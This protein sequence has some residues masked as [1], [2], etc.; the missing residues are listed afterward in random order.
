MEGKMKIIIVAGLFVWL[1][2]VLYANYGSGIA[3]KGNHRKDR[4]E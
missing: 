3:Y 2:V 4:R 1:M